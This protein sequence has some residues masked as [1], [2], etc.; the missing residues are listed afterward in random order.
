[1]MEANQSCGAKVLVVED[2]ALISEMIGEALSDSGFEVCV[3]ADAS[4]ALEH[5]AEGF[6]PDVLF[7]DIGL[8]GDMD[9]SLLA[10]AARKLCPDLP[11]VYASAGWDALNNIRTVPGSVFVPKPYSPRNICSLLARMTSAP[12]AA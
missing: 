3:A 1:M 12:V 8:P 11:V 6:E 9:G 10:F 7:T 4:E 2:E 5:L